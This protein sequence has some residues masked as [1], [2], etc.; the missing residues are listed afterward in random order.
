MK[1]LHLIEILLTGQIQKINL[2]DLAEE[3][4]KRN[5]KFEIEWKIE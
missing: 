2:T 1:L 3:N 4:K 5:S